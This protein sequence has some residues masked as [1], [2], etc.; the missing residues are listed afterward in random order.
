MS[1]DLQVMLR[2]PPPKS[3]LLTLDGGHHFSSM[4]PGSKLQIPN[5][6]PRSRVQ[7]A[8]R[9]GNIHRGADQGGLDM[10]LVMKD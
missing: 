6:L 7:P 2:P 9:D 5:P 8:I 4:F 3:F 10:S 1:T